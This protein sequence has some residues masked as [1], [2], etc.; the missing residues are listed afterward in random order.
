MRLRLYVIPFESLG[1]QRCIDDL[2]RGNVATAVL[3]RNDLLEDFRLRGEW[4]D[5]NAGNRLFDTLCLT[6]K[7]DGEPSEAVLK[8]LKEIGAL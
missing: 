2:R 6:L 7:V 5:L 8:K 3:D 4:L 1:V